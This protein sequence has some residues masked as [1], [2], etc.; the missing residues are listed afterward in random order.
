MV[1]N[2][3]ESS[4]VVEV[5]FKQQL[6]KSLMRLKESILD[7]L[8]EAYSLGEMVFLDTKENCFFLRLKT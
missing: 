7:K 3:S 8:N 6:D 1:H 2:N 5:N 4:L